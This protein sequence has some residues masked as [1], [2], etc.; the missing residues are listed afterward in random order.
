MVDVSPSQTVIDYDDYWVSRF[1]FFFFFSENLNDY[2]VGSRIHNVI[3]I[4]NI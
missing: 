4:Y 1:N 2:A 3:I